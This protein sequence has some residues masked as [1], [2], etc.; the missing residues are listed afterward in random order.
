MAETR[1]VSVCAATMRAAGGLVTR[2][3]DE[4]PPLS[5]SYAV[6]DSGRAL[7]PALEQIAQWAKEHLRA[8]E[9]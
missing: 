3:V 8:E 5:V 2:T 1:S 9:C 7:M 6:I 4:G